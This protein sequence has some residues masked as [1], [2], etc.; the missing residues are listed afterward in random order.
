MRLAILFTAVVLLANGLF[1]DRGL[2]ATVHARRQAAA[3]A[4]DIS[5]LRAANARLRREADALRHDPAAIEVVA[6]RELGML[7]PGETVIRLAR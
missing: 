7:R 6:R 1:G 3:L 5:T 4:A 2:A